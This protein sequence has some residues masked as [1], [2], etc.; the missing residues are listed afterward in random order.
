VPAPARR[1]KT[2]KHRWPNKEVRRVGTDA[3]RV[4]SLIGTKTEAQLAKQLLEGQSVLARITNKPMIIM[5]TALNAKPKVSTGKNSLCR[6]PEKMWQQT[7]KNRQAVGR[8]HL[9]VIHT[10]HV[11]CFTTIHK[12]DGQS[13]K[14]APTGVVFWRLALNTVFNLGKKERTDVAPH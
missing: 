2:G 13:G 8:K 14:T 9:F 1:P 5:A 4:V 3:T 11:S 12:R 10:T 6:L 7:S